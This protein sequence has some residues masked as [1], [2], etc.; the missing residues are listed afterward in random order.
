MGDNSFVTWKILD[1]DRRYKV[2]IIFYVELKINELHWL[3]KKWKLTTRSKDWNG[4]HHH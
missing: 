2:F 3:T 1:T 4:L